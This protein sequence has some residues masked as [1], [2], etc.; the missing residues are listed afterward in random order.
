MRL[1]QSLLQI[2]FP[3]TKEQAKLQVTLMAVSF[4]L[5]ELVPF[6]VVAYGIVISQIQDSQPKAG[7]TEGAENE[8]K[9]ILGDLADSV[10]DSQYKH[11]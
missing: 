11:E 8:N 1:L 6:T 5:A 3:E 7:D 10:N 4:T 9:R 2:F